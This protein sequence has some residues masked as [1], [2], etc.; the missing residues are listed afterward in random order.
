MADKT[1]KIHQVYKTAD[2]TIVPGVT[3]VIGIL[4]KPALLH[5][6]W[7]QGKAGLDLYKTRDKAASIGTIAHYMAECEI[8][9]I[10][11]D[12]DAYSKDD[13][14]KAETAFL[15]FLDFIKSNPIKVILSERQ[16]VS[17][18]NMFGG[19]VDIYG[20]MGG[21]KCLIDLKTS[22]GVYP[23]MVIQL[24]A[25]ANMLKENGH[26]VEGCHLLR[27]DKETGNFEHHVY[28]DLSRHWGLFL[29]LL[30]VYRLRKEIWKK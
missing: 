2:G 23:E 11:P 20:E 1:T 15:A 30:P 19:T 16:F 29:A 21:K 5:W 12:L 22:K 6:A 4:D 8:K 13:I 28:T 24:A 3:T 9:G 17:E 25:Y 10:K 18:R 7:E 14:D 27:I 26:E